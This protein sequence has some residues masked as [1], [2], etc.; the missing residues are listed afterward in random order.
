LAPESQGISGLTDGRLL[1]ADPYR[2]LENRI[3]SIGR[4]TLLADWN[5]LGLPTPVPG[6]I[7]VHDETLR[8][9]LQS[10]S[11]RQPELDDKLSLLHLMNRV[12]IDS[13]TIGMPV[14]G[15]AARDHTIRLAGEVAAARL[16]IVVSCA[17]RT[18]PADIIA[19]VNVAQRSGLPLWIM[20][21]VGAS[22]I[23]MY[24][25]GWTESSV[26]AQVASSVTLARREGL[27][28]CLVT[29]DTTRSPLSYALDVYS[30]AL[31][32]GA[33]R[34]CVCDT[35]GYATPWGAA[36]LV[37]DLRRG[38]ARRGF[39]DVGID[40]HGHND[41]GL[42]MANSL[43]AA[44]AGADRLHGTALGIG[45]RTGC[46]PMEQLLANLCDLGWRTRAGD[47]TALPRYCDL[48]EQSCAVV[49][50]ATQPL[51]GPDAYRTAAG[52]HASAIRK[53]AR[54]GDQWLAEHVY[55]GIPASAV[56]REQ[57]V[58]IGPGSG[59]SNI[60]LWLEG[61]GIPDSPALVDALLEAAEGATR[62]LSDGELLAVVA[63]YR[64]C[65]PPPA[66][67]AAGIL[68]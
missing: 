33:E 52:V 22:P 66:G 23:R 53:A 5:D 18:A 57:A 49:V 64:R 63:S 34:V 25:E 20:A 11:V 7:Q 9:G 37:G 38:L 44:L 13:V 1:A 50:P 62:V 36:R 45:E 35:V 28:V 68:V 60:L 10:P 54:R 27:R 3:M 39:A 56:G 16:P 43:A 31:G 29:E 24:T 15:P 46:A 30:A 40:W 4:D 14:S 21:F 12:G 6:N 67:R 26:L 19:V 17:A 41:R 59:R 61:Q 42:A 32:A 8:D 65:S 58:E 47:L 51:V 55:A 2:R 48:V